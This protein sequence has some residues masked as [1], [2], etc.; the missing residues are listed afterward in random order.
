[1]LGCYKEPTGKNIKSLQVLENNAQ[2]L[3]AKIYNSNL[4]SKCTWRF[5]HTMFIP[6]IMY[7]FPVNS[8]KSKDLDRIQNKSAQLF[9]P[10]LGYNRNTAK[11][12]V[13]GPKKY[14][15]IDLRLFRHEQ[16]LS[17]IEHLTQHWRNPETDAGKHVQ[18]ALHWIQY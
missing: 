3:T 10:K 14:G 6:S 18:I 11:A 9:L 7:S 12:I 4:D 8:I 17:K 1:M 13:Y 15:G 16:G 2:T 5:Y